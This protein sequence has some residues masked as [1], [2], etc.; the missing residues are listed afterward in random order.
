MGWILYDRDGQIHEIRPDG[1][2]DHRI[3]IDVPGSDQSNALSPDWSPDGRWIV[4]SMSFP[5][6]DALNLYVMRADG[7]NVRQITTA[8]PGTQE[9][10]E[11]DEYPDWG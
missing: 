1:S 9:V 5:G 7:S 8:L 11:G 4:F 10:G 2:G 6:M 3:G